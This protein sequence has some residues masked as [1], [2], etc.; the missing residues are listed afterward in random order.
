M[1]RIQ[2]WMTVSAAILVALTC[3]LAVT[4]PGR[5]LAVNTTVTPGATFNKATNLALTGKL[6]ESSN[7]TEFNDDNDNNFYSFYTS[8][9]DSSYKLSL[10]VYNGMQVYV[11]VY[12]SGRHRVAHFSTNKTTSYTFSN[13]KRGAKYY[14]EVWRYANDVPHAEY[15][16]AAKEVVASPSVVTGLK[17]TS[18]AEKQLKISFAGVYNATGYKIGYR[19]GAKE[20]WIYFKTTKRNCVIDGL[21]SG[22]KYTVRVC[23]YRTVN[24][25]NYRG[26]YVHSKYVTVQ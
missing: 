12:D 20:G 3:A 1:T 17:V 25:K 21:K 24:G 9:R 7:S 8:N 2:R 6:L 14:V 4:L 26:E 15:K 16:V 23:A 11:T 13:L 19:K 5:A 22:K 10:H 18:S